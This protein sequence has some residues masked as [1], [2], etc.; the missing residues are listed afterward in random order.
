MRFGHRPSHTLRPAGKF[1][2][3]V[4]RC[5]AISTNTLRVE[6]LAAGKEIHDKILEQLNPD[7][8]TMAAIYGETA[9]LLLHLSH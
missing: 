3:A 7:W 2:S 8:P 9:A 4:D 1:H 6:E 5:A